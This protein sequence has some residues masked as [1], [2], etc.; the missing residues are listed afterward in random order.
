MVYARIEDRK[1]LTMEATKTAFM[2][3]L[4]KLG[5]RERV[6]LIPPDITRIHGLGGMLAVWATEFYGGAVKQ[7]LPALGTHVPM[8]PKEIEVMYPGVDPALFTIHDWRN[9]IVTIG[10]VPKEFIEEVSEGKLSYEWKAQVNKA[11]VHG[12]FDLILSLGQVV[13]HE[14]IGMANHNKNV[15]VGTGGADGI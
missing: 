10:T 8:T 7:I 4:A 14:V 9:D 13:P 3:G 12:G 6:L 1:G 15:F 2:E 11:L 5:R